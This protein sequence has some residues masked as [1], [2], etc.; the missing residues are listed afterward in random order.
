MG[1]EFAQAREW[2]H[3]Q[4]LDWHLLEDAG[5]AGVQALVAELN[6]LY[7][8]E[9][10][11]YEEDT[12]FAGFQWIQADSADVN[13]YVFVRRGKKGTRPLLCVANLSPV[14]RHDYAF[15]APVDGTWETVL[16]TDDARFGGSGVDGAPVEAA[17]TPQDK[18]PARLVLTLPPLSVRWLVPAGG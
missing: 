17:P 2:N 4:S 9:G 11:L 15:G 14:V 16:N 6:R 7:A 3:D 1:D 8:A 18:Q 5:H 12:S 13:V 10:A